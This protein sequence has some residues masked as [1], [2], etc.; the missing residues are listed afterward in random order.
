MVKKHNWSGWP[1]AYCLNCGVEDAVENA[2]AF[3]WFKFDEKMEIAWK[4]E[5]LKKY[6]EY[7]NEHCLE[8]ATKEEVEEYCKELEEIKNTDDPI[9]KEELEKLKGESN[10]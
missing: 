7:L 1:G 9:F 6:V 10:G 4:S 2:L 5:T 3:D 8:G